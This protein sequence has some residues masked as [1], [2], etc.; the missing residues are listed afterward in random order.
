METSKNAMVVV[1]DE[2]GGGG[3]ATIQKVGINFNTS[4]TR[5]WIRHRPFA[6]DRAGDDR[7]HGKLVKVPCGNAWASRRTIRKSPSRSNW[8]FG[9]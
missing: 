2:K 1:R 4:F 5:Q 8:F 3:S 7:A 9:P 6:T